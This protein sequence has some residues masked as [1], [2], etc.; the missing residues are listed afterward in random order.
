MIIGNLLEQELEVNEE[1]KSAIKMLL[2]TGVLWCIGCRP[3]ESH[4]VFEVDKPDA[5]IPELK[6]VKPIQ[7]EAS[8]GQCQFGM[9]GEGCDLAVRMADKHYYVDGSSIDDHGNAHA[10]DGL[11]N[12]VRKAIVT[13]E[14]VDGRF[15]VSEM[16]LLGSVSAASNAQQN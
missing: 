9:P 5:K 8:C 11:C 15:V 13:G 1:M 16:T 6:F 3:Q 7:I 4:L 12:C 2:I 10:A 14:V